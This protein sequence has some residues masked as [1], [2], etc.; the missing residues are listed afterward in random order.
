MKK[1]LI[2]AAALA[3]SFTVPSVFAA[4]TD[5]GSLTI[6]GVIKGTTC[7]FEAGGQTAHIEM[8]QIGTNSLKDLEPGT[9]YTGYT[10]RASTPFKVVCDNA[11]T[12]PKIKFVSEQFG[13]QGE[14][15][16]TKNTSN[17][18][19]GVGYALFINN[20]RVDTTGN[21]AIASSLSE[22]GRYTF[23]ISAQ[24]ARL[25]GADVKAGE[26]NSSVTIMV[27]AD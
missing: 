7:H 6:H 18:A 22:N 4:E 8:Q 9:A 12:I 24:Y 23:D 25:P 5:S 3:M 2:V 15:S 1:S 17:D 21:T 27:I 20:D 14:N 13:I 19:E 16:V 11:N 26:V 10:N